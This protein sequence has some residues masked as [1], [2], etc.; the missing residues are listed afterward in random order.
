MSRLISGFT[1]GQL[2]PSITNEVLYLPVNLVVLLTIDNHNLHPL[3]VTEWWFSILS[4]FLHL[5]AIILYGRTYQLFRYSKIQFL[6]KKKKRQHKCLF[7]FIYQFPE[8]W[9]A[10]ATFRNGQWDLFVVDYYWKHLS[11]YPFHMHQPVILITLSFLF[12]F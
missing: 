9:I 6:P 4:L 1:Y 12:F 5:L 2:D 7:P 8:Y 10:P 3:K 11:F